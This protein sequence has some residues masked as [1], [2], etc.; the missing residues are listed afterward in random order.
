MKYHAFENT[1]LIS[2]IHTN[3]PIHSL[4]EKEFNKDLPKFGSLISILHNKRINQTALLLLLVQTP[5]Y[6]ECFKMIS[7]VDNTQTLIYNY[8]MRYP[9]LCK[10][11]IIHSKLK[12]IL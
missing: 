10:S 6:L 8:I 11:K 1:G 5:K 9:I 7:D 12:D 2:N 3:D 4:K